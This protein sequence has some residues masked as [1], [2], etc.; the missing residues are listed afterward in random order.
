MLVYALLFL[1]AAFLYF[2]P[3]KEND[4]FLFI[5]F[6]SVYVLVSGFRDMI[7][8]FD[9]YVYGEVFE[10]PKE[11]ILIYKQ[12]ENGFTIYF[13]ILKTISD[14][15]SFMFF[16]TALIMAM[17]HFRIIKVL[18]PIVY[19][20]TFI[21]FCK[22][23]LMSF[24]YLRQGLAMGIIWF[25]I[26]FVQDKKYLKFF[27]LV[28]IAYFFHKS[29]LVFIPLF[30]YGNSNIKNLQLIS[31]TFV[32]T[33]IATSSIGTEIATFFSEESENKKLL[34]YSKYNSGINFFYLFEIILLAILA[35]NFRNEFYKTKET[36]VLFNG[37]LGYI[38]VVIMGITN[39]TFI[40][41]SWYYLIFVVVALPHIFTFIVDNKKQQTFKLLVFSYFGLLFFRLLIS[42]DGGD[43]LPYKSIF[44]DFERNG[45]W[46]F[47][48]YR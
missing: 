4:T 44:Q 19:F 18:S 30:F 40:R 8:G 43:L 28:F 1:F 10:A 38:F 42:Y 45:M 7:G 36:T 34:M 11:F 26:P 20:S 12:F 21:F 15:R 32:L 27:A 2:K 25:A 23:F 13:I 48:E 22:F 17:L 3:N 47:M 37:L 24:V 33:I 46:E 5:V 29:S 41:F 9:V 14:N 31:I 6:V 35:L 39:A 16:V